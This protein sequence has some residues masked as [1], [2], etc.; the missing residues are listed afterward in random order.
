MDPTDYNNVIGRKFLD[1]AAR[2]ICT[3]TLVETPEQALTSLAAAKY[4]LVLSR[5]GHQTAGSSDAAQLLEGMRR[6]DLRAPVIIFASGDFAEQNRELALTLGAL[7]YT[8]SWQ[9]LFQAI[10]RRFSGPP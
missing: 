1:R 10:D 4:D 8:S 5:W 9:A 7:E 3:I 6:R 2:G